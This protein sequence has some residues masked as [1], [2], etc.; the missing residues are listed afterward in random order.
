MKLYKVVEQ[1]LLNNPKCRNSDK[2]LQWV[3]FYKKGL[4]QGEGDNST[5]TFRGFKDAPSTETIRR[6]RQKIVADYRV[7][8]MEYLVS[9]D[10]KVKEMRKNIQAQKG[11][12]VYRSEL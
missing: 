7:K 4:I 3:I 12:F 5:I 8:G 9:P 6:T 1:L 10:K 2:Y 11:T